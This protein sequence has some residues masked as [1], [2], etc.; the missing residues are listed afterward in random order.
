VV[1]ACAAAFDRVGMPEGRFHLSQATLYLATT[2]KS[3]TTMGVFDALAAVEKERAS[4][5]P[6]HL[7]DAN[8]DAK[9]MGHGAGYLYPHAY[10]AHWVAQQYLPTSLVGRVFWQP[11]DQ[12]YEGRVKLELERRREAQLAA[13]VEAA[14]EPFTSGPADKVTDKWLVRAQG[15][16]AAHLEQVRELIL[17]EAGIERH[18][19]V[20]DL[21]ARSGLLVWELVR[22][23][24]EG[25]VWARVD[26][27]AD[28]EALTEVAARLP[29]LRRPV[30]VAGEVLGAAQ[31]EGVVFDRVVGRDALGTALGRERARAAIDRLLAPGGRVVLVDVLPR[32]T[33]R[34]SAL[35]DAS[36]ATRAAEDRVY[37]ESA[38]QPD[39][40]ALRAAFP[41][42]VVTVRHLEGER[43]VVRSNLE[44]W[45][46]GE[47]SLGS[48]VAAAGGDAVALAAGLRGLE[49]K[50][51]PW[52]TT[53]AVIEVDG[54]G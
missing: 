32:Q 36:P 31:A 25:H 45:F 11:S 34:L 28:E 30:V 52:V 13:M 51:V 53:V 6:V 43:M 23:T 15:S 19:R 10:E 5:V 2:A 16:V 26:T 4:D 49:G 46:G 48:R 14:P 41:D 37:A 29:A 12:G 44:R 33:Q 40:E 22:R 17:A 54:A 42:A 8:R 7:K 27:A 21:E 1:V 9:G 18:H 39:E 3:N 35:V 47:G 38:L 20:L 24:P 50:T